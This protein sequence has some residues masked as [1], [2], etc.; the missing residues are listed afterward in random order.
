[1]H[2]DIIWEKPQRP[3]FFSRFHEF[4]C[5]PSWCNLNFLSEVGA[6]Q[7]GL[8]EKHEQL[9]CYKTT[10]LLYSETS[11][12]LGVLAWCSQLHTLHHTAFCALP[13]GEGT[14]EVNSLSQCISPGS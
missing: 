14:T 8:N 2:R 7:M 11:L 10:S 4:G 5:F 9:L 1:M 3:L 13:R 12:G 6:F